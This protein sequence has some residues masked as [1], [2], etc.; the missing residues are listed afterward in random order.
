[1]DLLK[2]VHLWDQVVYLL[3]LLPFDPVC[4]RTIKM[5]GLI[6][7]QTEDHP[8][9]QLEAIHTTEAQVEWVKIL[10]RIQMPCHFRQL[11]ATQMT[12]QAIQLPFAQV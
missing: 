1:L 4:L 6:R 8:Q 10:E 2:I 7:V 5:A 3:N 9:C 12:F 11:Q